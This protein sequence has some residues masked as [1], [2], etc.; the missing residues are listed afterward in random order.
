MKLKILI[1]L[2]IAIFSFSCNNSVDPF[3]GLEKNFVT[4]CMLDNRA[5]INL[6]R[7]HKIY[8]N[9]SS[10]KLG[11]KTAA[12]L[13]ESEGN[14]YYLKDTII[15]GQEDYVLFKIPKDIIKRDGYYRLTITN[16]SMGQQWA[17]CYVPK[18][19]GMEVIQ[20]SNP[21]TGHL[22]INLSFPRA[23]Y[24][25]IHFRLTMDY[26]LTENGKT[27]R[28][29][30]DIPYMLFIHPASFYFVLNKEIWLYKQEEMSAEFY[31]LI[32]I[33]GD[34]N[35]NLL[36]TNGDK[37]VRS[38]SDTMFQYVFK[39]M[40]L[41]YGGPNIKVKG[42]LAL[43]YSIDKNYYNQ[44]YLTTRAISSVRLD[45]GY[46]Y[47]NFNGGKNNYGFFGAITVDSVRFKIP[48]SLL[49]RFGLIDDQ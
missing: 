3:D 11:G 47:T 9:G 12:I 26:E 42:G 49:N 19:S 23:S 2:F 25:V 48:A 20:T 4:Y 40:S 7:I 45:G 17:D 13:S 38:Y 24:D 44:F 31:P 1:I 16:D 32:Q 5:D 14:E 30:M 15:T 34:T 28:K 8:F 29:L 6:V 22:Y 21:S 36:K 33:E 27:E 41:K 18:N 37:F 39:N 43:F 46:L 10:K 35:T